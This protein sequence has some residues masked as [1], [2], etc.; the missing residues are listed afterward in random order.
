MSPP[1]PDNDHRYRKTC[2]RYNDPGHAHS[3][4]FSC[5]QRQPFLSKDRSRQWLVEAIDRARQIHEFHIWA[6]VFMPEHAHLLLFPLKI[7]YSVSAILTSIK[8]PVSN[9]AIAFLKATAPHFLERM[10]DRQPN[11]RCVLRFWQRGGGHDRNLW[12][13]AHIWEK[14]DYIHLN[15]VRRGL[16]ETPA[17][18]FWSSA[19]FYAGKR[20][21][22]LPIQV[23][24]IPRDTRGGPPLL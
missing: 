10:R 16:C 18:W 2:R 15:P 3:F 20:D 22:P 21:G 6:Y 19:G 24:H 9:R 8:K 1:A 5:F 11:G 7:G 23:D 4:T 14:I 12:S 13:P 17:E